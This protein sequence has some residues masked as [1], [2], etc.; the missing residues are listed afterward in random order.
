MLILIYGLHCISSTNMWWY[1]H[2]LDEKYVWRH[3]C[4]RNDLE[5]KTEPKPQGRDVAFIV[6]YTH[7]KAS[8]VEKSMQTSNQEHR[9]QFQNAFAKNV[10]KN[11]VFDSVKGTC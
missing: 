10:V 7:C 11:R 2:C 5:P 8:V 3:V 4:W 6:A 1:V 9:L